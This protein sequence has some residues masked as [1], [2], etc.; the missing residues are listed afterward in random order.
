MSDVFDRPG[1]ERLVAGGMWFLILMMMSGI[2]WWGNSI[3]LSRFY[4]PEGYGIFN[5]ATSMHNFAWVI[6]F[7]GLFEG[8][9]KYGSEYVTKRGWRLG[10]YFSTTINYLTTIGIVMFILL[11]VLAL[12]LSDPIMR[13]IT[14]TIA[15]SFLFSGT[16]DALAS[17]IGAFQQSDYLSIINSSRAIVVFFVSV[18]FIMLGVPSYL[19]PI[20]IVWATVWQLG[21]CMYFLRDRLVKLLPLNIGALFGADKN[22]TTQKLRRLDNFRQFV[23]IFIF[24]SFISLGLISFS[25][26][27][28]LDIIVLKIFF[29]YAD[30]GVYSIADTASSILF[31]MTSFS[32][33]IIPAIAEAYSTKNRELL[34]DYVRIAVKYPVLI[35][36]PLTIIVLTMAEPLIIGVYG[37]VFAEAVR[38]LQVLIIG[39]FMLMFGYNLASVLIGIGKSKISGALMF[40][41]ALQ[42]IISLFILVPLFGFMG[43]AF[44]LT[45]T[46]FTSMLLVPYYLRREL[47]I[48]IYRELWKVIF[49][50]IVV[51]FI[52]FS[53]PR[54]NTLFII[55]E[56]VGGVGLFIILLYMLGYVTSEDLY[57]MKI[58]SGTFKNII[59]PKRKK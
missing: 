40:V 7:G 51:V 2:F 31:Y 59:K 50:A 44:S 16:K 34:K 19:L 35:G 56:I 46:G 57:M 15:V 32:W 20:L 53:I 13:I 58:A 17:I 43:A 22:R 26:M 11:A 23:K 21:L 45:L 5:I 52:L 6:V 48:S 36:M 9:M 12:S 41:A 1:P 25:V 39:T 47:K 24:G 33:P 14:L 37:T 29:D 8:L 30:V 18:A 10:S 3:V 55:F 42:Y 49:A 28:S 27:K 4:G 38:P 54:P